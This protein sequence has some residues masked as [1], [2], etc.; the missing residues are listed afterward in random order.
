[1][2]APMFERAHKLL[3]AVIAERYV[4]INLTK[5]E[6]GMYLGK[7]ED[8]QVLRYEFFLAAQGSV[9]ESQIRDRLP[10]LSKIASWNHISSILN[11]AVNGAKLDLEYRPPGA[12]PV[13][14]GVIFFKV[15][16]TPEYWNDIAGTGTIAIYQPME[17]SSMNLSLYAVDPANL[18]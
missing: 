17:P 2:F 5:R 1:M 9:P 10:K 12:L 15:I 16:R 13:K 8:P 6:D 3:D 11:S 4:Q 7:I 14:P 18:Q